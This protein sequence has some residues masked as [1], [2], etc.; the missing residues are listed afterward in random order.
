MSLC[1]D[2]HKVFKSHVKSSQAGFFYSSSPMHFPWP[3]PTEN[4][5]VPEPNE[6]YHLYSRGT[7]THHK[8]YMSCDYHPALRDV[9]ADTGNTASS[10]V[11]CWTVFIELL[12]GNELIKSVTILWRIWRFLRNDFP[13]TRYFTYERCYSTVGYGFGVSYATIF[14]LHGTNL[15]VTNSEAT[16][17]LEN[18]SNGKCNRVGRCLLFQAQ[19]LDLRGDRHRERTDRNR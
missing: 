5:L 14:Q 12:P 18:R 11:A 16:K 6:F 7:N 19:T 8:K 15:T 4:W 17:L 1:Y 13:N 10:I 9:T 2:T 3:S